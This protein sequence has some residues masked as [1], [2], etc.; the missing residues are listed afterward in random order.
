M[1]TLY[2]FKVTLYNALKC[3]QLVCLNIFSF[4][5]MY[6][7]VRLGQI[8]VEIYSNF[9]QFFKLVMQRLGWQVHNAL[10]YRKQKKYLL[11][12]AISSNLSL[13]KYLQ[14]QSHFA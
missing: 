8:V 14:V 3:A 11:C 9:K 1:I 13:N 7:F 4:P 6:T 10:P 2:N 12:L 5:K